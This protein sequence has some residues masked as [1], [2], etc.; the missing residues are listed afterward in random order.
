VGDK[1]YFKLTVINAT[2]ESVSGSL[3][4]RGHE[5]YDCDP[6]NSLITIPRN[7][8]YPPGVTNTFYSFKV[9][10]AV[11]PG[12]YSASVKSTLN[13]GGFEVF[14][15]MNVDIVLCVPWKV[16]ENTGW[17]LVEV[18]REEVEAALPAVTTLA[19]NY[20]N[21][22][23]ATTKIS[24][25]LATAGEITLKVYDISGRLVET[26]VDRHREPGS[27]TASWDASG[28]SSGVYFYKLTCGEYTATKK[29]NLLK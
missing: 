1:F 28:V 29:M 25:D 14:C 9:P 21:P 23:N 18:D 15:C 6:W 11:G 2:A 22:F 19:Q 16:G 20:P 10:N 7:K 3:S 4:F 24:Y 8:T 5:G 13:P 17:E 12:Q 27:Y 26:L